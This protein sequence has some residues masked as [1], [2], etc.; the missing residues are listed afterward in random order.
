VTVGEN[1]RSRRPRFSATEEERVALGDE[2]WS[3]QDMGKGLR[4][5][6]KLFNERGVDISHATVAELI[7]EAQERAKFLDFVGPAQSRAASI[8]RLMVA[9][10]RSIET[11]E[12]HAAALKTGELGGRDLPYDKA[13][14]VLDKAMARYTSLEQ[15]FIKVTGAAMPTR[16]QI[17]SPDG[18]PVPMPMATIAGLER[19]VRAHKQQTEELEERYGLDG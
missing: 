4:T 17:E 1:G 14:A 9:L 6:Q 5:I 15:L 10:E 3:L 11:I 12:S 7:K 2:A 16:T 8:G 13:A 19:A 18:G